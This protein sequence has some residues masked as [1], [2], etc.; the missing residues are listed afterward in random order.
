MI[1]TETE[2]DKMLADV[3]EFTNTIIRIVDLN[4]P[5]KIKAEIIHQAELIFH[6]FIMNEIVSKCANT[7][8][9]SDN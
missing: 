3:A 6:Q 4:A 2:Y 5:N 7:T 8:V 9:P 1:A